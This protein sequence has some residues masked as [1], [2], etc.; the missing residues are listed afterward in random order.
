[1]TP[2]S[3]LAR[4]LQSRHSA[5]SRTPH[6]VE[7][8][9]RRCLL[10]A[11]PQGSEF[12][13]NNYIPRTQDTGPH[14]DSAA[15]QPD[16]G[17]VVV[18][19]GASGG[20][21]SQRMDDDG[22]YARLYDANGSHRGPEFL[23]N[24]VTDGEQINPSVATAADGSFVVVWSGNGRD[25]SSGQRDTRG[26]WGQRF[27]ADGSKIGSQFLVN[28]TIQGEQTN[29][30]IAMASDGR[31][32]VTWSGVGR[33]DSNG[34]VDIEGVYF[35]QFA[36][37]GTPVGPETAAHSTSA[38]TQAL[39]SVAIDET[40]DFVITW[41][42]LF[43]DGGGWGVYAQRFSADGARVGGE[44]RVND[45]TASDQKF[46][47]V[48]MADNGAFAI[49]WSSRTGQDNSD[50]GVYFRNYSAD[51]AALRGDTLVNQHTNNDQR[52]SKIAMDGTGNF[53]ITWDSAL[54]DGSGW[55]VYA[56]EYNADG[57]PVDGEFAV[58]TI[59]LAS[60]RHGSVAVSDDG[61]MLIVWNGVNGTDQESIYA[62]RYATT[63]LAPILDPITAQFTIPEESLFTFTAT[64]SDPDGPASGLRFSLDSGAPEGAA[65]DALTGVF[66]WTPSEAQ[67]P[68]TFSITVRLT[69]VRGASDSQTI[70]F[71]VTEVN[72]DPV[73][74]QLLVFDV[75]AGEV[76][77]FD[78][79]ATDADLPANT[80][81]FSLGTGGA[82][83]G[84]TLTPRDA[85][86]TRFTWASSLDQAGQTFTFTVNVTDGNGGF[87]STTFDIR[88]GALPNQAPVLEPI[89]DR[90]VN[91]GELLTFIVSA[92]DADTP[93]QTLTFAATGLPVGATF[94][95]V[96][97]VFSWT[98]AEDQ[99]PGTYM[100]TFTVTDSGTPSQSASETITITVLEV[101]R[102]PNLAPIPDMTID[103]GELLTFTATATD[104]DLPVQTL[105]FSLDDS[106][107]EGAAIDPVTGV[108]T[109]TPTA[110]QVGTFVIIV[111]VTDNGSPALADSETFTVTVNDINSPPDIAAIDTI[112]V[113]EL[114]TV[115]FTATAVDPEGNSFTW[116]LGNDAPP[117]ATIDPT[118]GAFSWTPSEEQGPGTY[119][120]TL[121]ATDDGD[122]P[123]TGT[124][125]VT[126]VVNEVNQNPLFV[127]FINLQTTEAIPVSHQFQAVDL[128]LPAQTLTFSIVS[129]APVGA[130]ISDNGL[131]TY[132]PT[133][134]DGGQT[135]SI[136]I[137][138]EDGFGG[139]VEGTFQLFI[140]EVNE[141][142]VLG[143]IGNRRIAADFLTS[144][145]V[146]AT[147]VDLPAQ[148]LTLS[149][150]NLPD[151]ATF[152]PG[153][154]LFSWTP[155]AAQ[156][157]TFQVT[158]MVSDGTA[159]DMEI[160][161]FTV[162]INTPP[163]LQAIANQS[164][165]ENTPFTLTAM[166]SD[167]E[168]N[169]LTFSLGG[170]V[171]AGMTIDPA[172]GVISWTPAEDQGGQ[173]FTVTVV[174]TDDGASQLSDSVDFMITVIEDNQAPVV[175]A[176][177]DQTVGAG[178]TLSVQ[179]QAT[180]ADLPA[181]TLTYSLVNPPANASIN[182]STGLFTFAPTTAQTGMTFTIM[183][184]VS[185]GQTSTA[186]SFNVVVSA[187]AP[188]VF[189]PLGDQTVEELEIL[190][191]TVK[192]TDPEGKAVTYSMSGG[193]GNASFNTQ[194]GAFSFAATEAQGGQV[195]NITFTATDADGFSS[196]MM[197]KVTVIIVNLPPTFPV[198][199]DQTIPEGQLF[200]LQISVFDI[201]DEVGWNNF[202]YSTTGPDG[203]AISSSGLFTWTP[204]EAQGPGVYLV[205]ITVTDSGI[206]PASRTREFTITVTE[207]NQAPV[208]TPPGTQQVGVGQL[209]TVNV[210]ATDAD[211]PAQ[212]L[213][214]SLSGT[215]PIGATINSSTGVFTWTPTIVHVGSTVPIT[216]NVS[217]GVT[218]S[219]ATFNVM[220]V[221]GN[222]P[223]AI[224]PIPNLTVT[225][226]DVVNLTIVATD[227]EGGT[228]TFSLGAGAPP[229]LELDPNT[230]ELRW[231]TTEADGPNV[232]TITV[233][234]TDNGTPAASASR[235][236]T[237]TVNED[238]EPPVI[239]SIEDK[240][241]TVGQLLTFQV[242]A[243]DPDLPAQTLAYELIGTV[244]AGALL[245]STTGVF[246]W[247][248]AQGQAQAT[249]YNL[250]IKVTDS[251]GASTTTVVSIQ[252]NEAPPAPSALSALQGDEDYQ[253]PIGD[254]TLQSIGS[255]NTSNLGGST[256]GTTS[257]ASDGPTLAPGNVGV[258]RRLQQTAQAI[259][260]DPSRFDVVL[261]DYFAADADS[262][263]ELPFDQVAQSWQD[264]FEPNDWAFE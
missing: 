99:G 169:G 147:D 75:P 261:D 167:A 111:L 5:K 160:V 18:F 19:A 10:T 189:D 107:P 27:A 183:V 142:P 52:Y 176:V 109:W 239:E 41:S 198:I 197:V 208:I 76:I 235:T 135:Y 81:T 170:S 224:N 168:G 114:Q 62:R 200:S 225:E 250:T 59:T 159:T 125:Q 66:T 38:N 222:S 166:A 217:D 151:G 12:L 199:P 149:A 115:N 215:V 116:S 121:Q 15:Y 40:G 101:N 185:D 209:L 72:Q 79:T 9:E 112:T 69:D 3:T 213:T 58:N 102:S 206:P 85:G 148:T 264:A 263:D 210:L 113:D 50:W 53:V 138:V 154:G 186:T 124:R 17:F 179:I 29:P 182:A 39:S 25:S 6:L 47:R 248:P 103:E 140:E 254:P 145:T 110:S 257:P 242:V 227:P 187:N 143:P 230:G 204:T 218:S 35:R 191:F 255:S 234:A 146:S 175:Q 91:E 196:T 192:A 65:I 240:T 232:Y 26:I 212:T 238:N 32:V 119:T 42:S 51:G 98:P 95:P 131:F 223:P 152:D 43:Q 177:N 202:S 49:T 207:V 247:T 194:T 61:R 45:N 256:G 165:T 13:V 28:E 153:T 163:V 252:V 162:E 229:A 128:D 64:G 30:T 243:S 245:N 37:D 16:G 34:T 214:Y 190:Q 23:V 122:P 195:F 237:I 86:V 241:A 74:N 88:V 2:F 31:F 221:G 36:A 262:N 211:L 137:R 231:A 7:A 184:E 100:V 117:G 70:T 67:G 89:G 249:P 201:D 181:Q 78:I 219:S 80:L 63:N 126:I 260:R 73:I 56:R 233:I 92:T 44:F 46:S 141:A 172:T 158:F 180:D 156:L 259:L 174:V 164:A 54:Q 157:G 216:V 20:N 82:E 144:F 87:D 171:P 8:L 134:E 14:T 226:G 104:P 139:S 1:M 150:L 132:T 118:T 173:T 83:L 205:S 155:T 220:V 60:Q 123:A 133:E 55:G 11:A 120:F 57:S 129:G 33:F 24:T 178:Q 96:T 94:D 108:F 105:T 48:A 193:P 106:A 236:F 90:T 68:G 127:G 251:L 246:T 244:P 130:A 84:A 97:R 188:P 21:S 258:Q 203:V 93:A 136:T 4:R 22:I 161:E 228:V 71:N 77:F 253:Q